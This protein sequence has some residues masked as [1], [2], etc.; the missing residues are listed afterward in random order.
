MPNGTGAPDG[1]ILTLLIPWVIIFAV[2]YFILILPQ[3]K[4][5]KRTREMLDALKVGDEVITVGGIIGK[6]VSIKDDTV[7]IEVGADKTKIKITR[8]AIATVENLQQ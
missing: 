3:K 8:R 4:R 1:N 6:I 2:F 7:T 5:D